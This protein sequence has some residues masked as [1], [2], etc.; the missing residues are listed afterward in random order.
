MQGYLARVSH[1]MAAVESVSSRPAMWGPVPHTEAAVRERMTSARVLEVI[2][3][4]RTGCITS[5]QEIPT[6]SHDSIYMIF[7][8][9]EPSGLRGR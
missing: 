5:Q 4:G 6:M 9:H 7:K 2:T 8:S 3:S 1:P